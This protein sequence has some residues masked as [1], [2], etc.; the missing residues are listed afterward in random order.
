MRAGSAAVPKPSC[1]A[2]PCA[3]IIAV[4]LSKYAARSGSHAARPPDLT[5]TRAAAFLNP[6][7]LKFGRGFCAR[8]LPLTGRPR[9]RTGPVGR[10]G[11]DRVEEP[12]HCLGAGEPA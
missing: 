11:I 8:L 12:T 1:E 4:V 6:Q 10:G 9:G 3:G 5:L 2:H 7:R